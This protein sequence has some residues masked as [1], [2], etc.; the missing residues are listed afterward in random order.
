MYTIEHRTEY[1]YCKLKTNDKQHTAIQ[2]HA[3]TYT[4]QATKMLFAWYHAHRV[5]HT[6]YTQSSIVERHR[7]NSLVQ[8]FFFV[9]FFFRFV[10]FF[11]FLFCSVAFSLPHSLLLPVSSVPQ[12][13][14]M[15][16]FMSL[17][18]FQLFGSHFFLYFFLSSSV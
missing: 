3:C 18:L 5:R 4:F 9:F 8:R 2:H 13:Y 17:A 14:C 15:Y 1:I 7:V 11:L 12:M 16:L 10:A 6:L